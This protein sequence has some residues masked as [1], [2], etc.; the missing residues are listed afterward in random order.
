MNTAPS[1]VRAL[2]SDAT[3]LGVQVRVWP[4][5]LPE[6]SRPDD[7]QFV[8]GYRILITNH[9]DHV[10]QVL[11]R[12]WLIVD[13]GGRSHEVEGPGVV[14]QQ[15]RIAPGESFE[16]S[17]FCPLPTSWGTME[18]TYTLRDEHSA[19]FDIKIARFYLVAPQ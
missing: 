7:A 14:G 2:G 10:V 13:A 3:T 11:S 15:P 4:Q 16:Y 1:T 17:S 19:T 6:E 18:G 12:R 9:R 8:F 5:F